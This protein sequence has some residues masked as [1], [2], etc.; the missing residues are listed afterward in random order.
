MDLRVVL[1]WKYNGLT[2]LCEQCKN[3]ER[4]HVYK[5]SGQI[6]QLIENSSGTV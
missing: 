1:Y 6:F 4:F 5:V 2:G 3:I